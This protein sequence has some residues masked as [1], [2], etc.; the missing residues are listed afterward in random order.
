MTV[1]VPSVDGTAEA[2]AKAAAERT[3]P[4][5]GA[6]PPHLD[7]VSVLPVEDKPELRVVTK[8]ALQDAAATVLAAANAEEGLR[9]Q[10]LHRPSVILSDI[11]TPDTDGYELLR[12]VRQLPE[13]QGAQ[14]PAA[15]VYAGPEDRQRALAAGFQLHL[16]K[17]VS[18]AALPAT[19]GALAHG[20]RRGAA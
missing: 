8:Q 13:A 1:I 10:R 16:A 4:P 19:L 7:G 2:G 14:T 15:A 3:T 9:L 6:A 20:A 17:P 18:P 12:R 5:E 11:G